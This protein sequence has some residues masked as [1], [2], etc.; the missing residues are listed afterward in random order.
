MTERERFDRL[1][2]G[3]EKNAPVVCDALCGCAVYLDEIAALMHLPHAWLGWKG[4][5]DAGNDVSEL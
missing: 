3:G 4:T 1:F 5:G 2:G